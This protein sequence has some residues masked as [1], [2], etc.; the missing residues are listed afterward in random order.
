MN[1]GLWAFKKR[2]IRFYRFTIT[3]REVRLDWWALTQRIYMQTFAIYAMKLDLGIYKM[4][5]SDGF[6]VVT[7][8]KVNFDLGTLTKHTRTLDLCAFT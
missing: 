4:R 5:K 7:K 3:K 1:L 8:R 6:L 2:A